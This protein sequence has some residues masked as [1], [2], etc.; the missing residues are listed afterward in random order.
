MVHRRKTNISYNCLDVHTQT[1]RRNKLA[2]IWEGEKGEFRSFSYFALRRDTCRFANVLKSLGVKKGD[3]G[4][5][6]YGKNSRVNDRDACLRKDRRN[7]TL[8]YMAD[9]PLKL[10]MKDLKDSHSK[11]LITADGSYQRGK[12][13]SSLK[14]S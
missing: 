11:I 2:L 3:R 1:H 13:C 9:F 10:F 4:N 5:F 14:Q 7:P 12:T 8:L 6:I